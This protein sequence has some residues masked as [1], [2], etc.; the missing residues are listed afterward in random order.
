MRSK[1]T[2]T[3]GTRA[4]R[5]FREMAEREGIQNVRFESAG[6]GRHQK[7]IGEYGGRRVRMPISVTNTNNSDWRFWKNA[8]AQIRRTLRTLEGQQG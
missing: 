1:V 5:Q 7:L 3:P 4:E 8:R 6:R 2:H